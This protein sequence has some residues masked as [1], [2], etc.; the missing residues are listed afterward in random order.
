MNHPLEDEVIDR[1]ID[2]HGFLF[3]SHVEFLVNNRIIEEVRAV[4]RDAYDLAVK[5]CVNWIY[6]YESDSLWPPSL[7]YIAD[8]LEK[9]MRPNEPYI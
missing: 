6:N 8:E 4:A 9:A 1:M 5:H 2:K 3:N 7:E